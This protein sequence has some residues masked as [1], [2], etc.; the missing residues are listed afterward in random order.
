MKRE[1]QS[2]N[3]AMTVM[4]AAPKT[5][6]TQAFTPTPAPLVVAAVKLTGA[7]AVDAFK[8]M[9]MFGATNVGPPP[10]PVLLTSGAR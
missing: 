7:G 6:C 3:P 5:P 4:N 10:A 8:D 9:L 1:N 2:N